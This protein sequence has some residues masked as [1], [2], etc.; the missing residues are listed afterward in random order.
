MSQL[1]CLFYGYCLH[2]SATGIIKQSHL[3]SMHTF[4]WAFNKCYSDYGLE[5]Q[6]SFSAEYVVMVQVRTKNW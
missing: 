5:E 3:N 4:Y 6:N 1:V 2:G